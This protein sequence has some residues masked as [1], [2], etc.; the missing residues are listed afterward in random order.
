MNKNYVNLILI[1]LII[2]ILINLLNSITNN[3]T[4]CKLFSLNKNIIENFYSNTNNDIVNDEIYEE[5][6]DIRRTI[7][8]LMSTVNYKI[9]SVQTLYDDTTVL[10]EEVQETRNDWQSR[11][12]GY[13]DISNDFNSTPNRKCYKNITD[14][15]DVKKTFH[16][17]A[18]ECNGNEELEIEGD[19]NCLSFSY[20]RN[21]NECR[22]SSICYPDTEDAITNTTSLDFANTLYVKKNKNDYYDIMTKFDL[23]KNKQCN[24]LCYNDILGS[25]SVNHIHK[26]AQNC[27]NNPDCVSFEYIFNP[28]EN[29]NNC[30]F[31]SECNKDYHVENSDTFDC[32][33]GNIIEEN[34]NLIDEINYNVDGMGKDRLDNYSLR[35]LKKKCT[36][37]CRKN[38]NCNAFSYYI[39]QDNVNCDLYE[40][41][42]ANY[43]LR[44][45]NFKRICQIKE[46]VK[47]KNLYT[48]KE[49]INRDI[50]ICEGLCEYSITKDTPYI[51][52]FTS[53]NDK[54][55]SYITF[56]D[57]YN[58]QELDNFNLSDYSHINIKKGYEVKFYNSNNDYI[59]GEIYQNPP[60]NVGNDFNNPDYKNDI[61]SLISQHGQDISKIKITQLQN[62]N[63][64]MGHYKPCT[65]GIRKYQLYYDITGN[66][67]NNC[68]NDPNNDIPDDESC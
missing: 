57:M 46:D 58:I 26:C 17:C 54:N 68:R 59:N 3:N 5:V 55:Y 21:T 14:I 35:D 22:L 63:C 11:V 2:I 10:K 8:N 44:D 40:N 6:E 49:R 47:K 24:D 16:E 65:N 29:Q 64:N 4:F 12:R 37:D 28:D 66:D 7:D 52:F 61:S 50:G 18:A 41:L 20:D 25:S 15:L 45:N 42:E 43:N 67:L 33:N 31:R 30:I 51:K 13:T 23:K 34:S 56:T 53:E 9:N 62:S 32:I 36:D 38:P 27:D 60:Y 48:H 19:D 1:S 39:D